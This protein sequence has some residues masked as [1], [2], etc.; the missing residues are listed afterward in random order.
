M[1]RDFSPWSRLGLEMLLKLNV[2]NKTQSKYSLK[3][4]NQIAKR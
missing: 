4:S 3:S 2:S 1:M